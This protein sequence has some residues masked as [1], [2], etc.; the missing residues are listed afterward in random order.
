VENG[1]DSQVGVVILALADDFGAKGGLGAL[2]E[3]NIVL[4]EDV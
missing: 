2:S 4:L 1:S 3:L